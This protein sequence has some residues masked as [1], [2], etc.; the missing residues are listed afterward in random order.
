MRG[1]KDSRL[2]LDAVC[3]AAALNIRACARSSSAFCFSKSR[4]GPDTAP[5]KHPRTLEGSNDLRFPE[6]LRIQNHRTYP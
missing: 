2:D 6:R 5:G 3:P 4:P 1:P